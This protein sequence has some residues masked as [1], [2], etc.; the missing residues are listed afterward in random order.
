MQLITDY[1]PGDL[2]LKTVSKVA[3]CLELF[4]AGGWVSSP[5]SVASSPCVFPD[6]WPVMKRNPSD[7]DSPTCVCVCVSAAACEKRALPPFA[8]SLPLQHV[9][10]PVVCV[11]VC[12]CLCV[13]VTAGR[14]I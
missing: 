6:L 1:H 3:A 5:C 13:S 14:G 9:P 10:V 12:V 11:C 4:Q 8:A 2:F 7:V